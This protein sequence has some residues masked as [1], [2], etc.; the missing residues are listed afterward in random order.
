MDA[1][2]GYSQSGY[3]YDAYGYEAAGYSSEYRSVQSPIGAHRSRYGAG[4]RGA[5]Q[6]EGQSCGMMAVVPVYPVYQI[7][8]QPQPD[9]Q[10]VEAPQVIEPDPV[11]YVEPAPVYEPPV[12]E[13]PVHHWPE[14]KAPV[15]DWKP[16]RK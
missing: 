15:T 10:V 16:L 6:T 2:Y 9:V 14:P 11:P 1:G 13:P 12:Y 4:L 8:T 3:G 7:V 5:C